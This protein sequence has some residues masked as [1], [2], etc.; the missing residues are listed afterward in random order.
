[1]TKESPCFHVIELEQRTDAWREWR[2]DGIGASDAPIIMGENPWKN[3]S[4]LLSLKQGPACD[5]GR[6]A[7]M[8]FGEECEA[9]AL[10]SYIQ[11]K[12]IAVA[13]LCLESK[14]RP[15]MR[16]SLDGI[17]DDCSVVVEIKCGLSIYRKVSQYKMVPT[18]YNGQLQHILA[19][20][21]LPS[22]D[23]WCY[24]PNRPGL[25]VKIRRDDSYI[26]RLITAETEFW[27]RVQEGR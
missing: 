16:A 22:L 13:P 1:M 6:N 12:G 20:T 23:F 24:L 8:N 15:W 26:K 11:K 14:E 19:L 7:A 25:L 5:P 4:G 27:Q 2:H 10:G 3:V 21:G 17:S 9:D 18:Y